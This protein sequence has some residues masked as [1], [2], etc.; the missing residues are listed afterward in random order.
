MRKLWV[1]AGVAILMSAVAAQAVEMVEVSV[2]VTEINTSK[3]RDMGIT[4]FDTIQTGELSLVD[5][6]KIPGSLPEVPSL[7]EVGDW[8]RYTALTADLKLLLENGAA[9]VLS[10][11]KL[12]TKSGSSAKFLVGGEFPIVSAGVSGGSVDWKEYG[13]KMTVSPVITANKMVDMEVAT[14]VSRMDWVNQVQGMPAVVTRKTNSS[15]Q[16]KNGQTLTLAGMIE[17]QKSET[18]V[19]LPILSEIPLLGRLFS[20]KRTLETKTNVLIFVTPRII[21]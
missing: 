19:G 11:P 10:K 17:T 6:T 20:R 4:W 13:I 8:K 12:V 3:A 21:E 2:E 14:E 15:V 5:A 1:M 9:Q 16:V 18:T 7:V